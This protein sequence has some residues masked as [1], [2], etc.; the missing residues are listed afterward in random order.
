M[1]NYGSDDLVIE[2]DDSVGGSLTNIKAYIREIGGFKVEAILQQAHAFGDTWVEHLFTGLRQANAFAMRGFYDD[3]AGGPD[4]LFAG[5]E[6]E[7]RSLRLTW[8]ST[9]TSSF[10]VLIQSYER[11]PK[12]GELHG[13]EV[14]VQP[15][16]AVTEA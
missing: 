4:A 7:V 10:E 2:V 12:V 5:H 3:A 15:T 13:F 6:G 11:L 1:A 14:M 8:G 9:K 16:G